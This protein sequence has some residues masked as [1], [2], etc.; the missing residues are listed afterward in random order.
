M[1]Q[2]LLPSIPELLA[3]Y[4]DG[5]A[6]PREFLLPLRD[7]CAATD[8]AIWIH[9]L[10]RE[11]V[12]SYIDQLGERDPAS[13]PL[14]GVPFAI[15]D[16]IDLAGAPTTAA[17]PDY[18]YVPAESATVVSLLIEAGA[19]PFGK[20]NL[21]QF[22]TGLVGLRS[23]YGHPENPWNADY[24]PGG[25]SSGS[26][27]AV[28]R[29]LVSF[30]LGTDTAGS[31]RV[32]AS[33]NHLVGIKP[34]RGLASCHGVVPACRSLDCVTVFAKGIADAALVM[35]TMTAFDPA[36]TYSRE[37]APVPP[38]TGAPRIGIPP[39][40]QLEFFGNEESAALYREAVA[41]CRALGWS[42]V[43]SDLGPMLEA[44]RLL[45]EGPWVAERLAAI[46]PFLVSQPDSVHPVTRSIIMGGSR[47]SAVDCFRAEYRLRELMGKA[48]AAWS[49]AD[50][51]LLPTIGTPFTVAE[52]EAAPIAR[53]SELGHYTNF[54]NLLDYAA[55]AVPAG[56]LAS[57][58]MPWGVTLF[59][60]AFSDGFLASLGARFLGE[61]PELLP[62]E[63]RGEE[64]E[65]VVCGAH[66]SGLPLN[67]QLL[68]RGAR[69]L[70]STRTAPVYRMFVLPPSDPLPERPGLVRFEE[71]GAV[72]EVEVWSVPSAAFGSFVANIAAPLGIGRIL[73]EDGREVS[74]FLCESHA[75]AG[76]VEIT[77][78]AGWRSYLATA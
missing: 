46:E 13:L 2:I 41:R 26:A 48:D 63:P 44:A 29:G 58:G 57:I 23:P 35:R 43:E 54:M 49:S 73:L 12:E 7:A 30:A 77:S 3:A 52:V 47:H 6:T 11:E 69:L 36:D 50:A 27:V 76:T 5:T 51:I 17:C 42:I 33:L 71:G 10:S 67:H 32:P 59:G 25:S 24:I 34:T 45:Y 78:L 4:R 66:L 38:P 64:I 20:T 22:A 70:E 60:P 55:V 62:A 40:D 14:Y 37:S 31:G 61:N 72:I 15:K 74:G 75:I 8:P 39:A 9:L 53:N 56:F 19:I 1:D 28:A 16:N 68:S 65:V 18:A 21:D